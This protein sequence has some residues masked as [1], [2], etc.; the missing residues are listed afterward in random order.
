M[1]LPYN[2]LDIAIVAIF[3]FLLFNDF[4]H[5]QPEVKN[6]KIV[7]KLLGNK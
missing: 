4:T 7:I 1:A 3:F 6:F 5:F 2:K